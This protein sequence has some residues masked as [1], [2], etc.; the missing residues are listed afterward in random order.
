MGL[1]DEAKGVTQNGLVPDIELPG[2]PLQCEMLVHPLKLYP[3]QDLNRKGQSLPMQDRPP[4][5]EPSRRTTRNSKL[6]SW[7]DKGYLSIHFTTIARG[8]RER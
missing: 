6:R 8:T 3:A 2:L 1:H 5:L 7:K 4:L